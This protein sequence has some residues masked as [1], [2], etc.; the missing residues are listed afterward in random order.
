MKHSIRLTGPNGAHA[1]LSHR[2][3][4]SFSPATARKYHAQWLAA[5]PGGIARIETQDREP[6][7]RPVRSY[8]GTVT[9]EQG[10]LLNGGKPTVRSCRFRMERD[11]ENWVS[12]M[13]AQPFASVGRVIPSM[14]SPELNALTH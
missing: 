11:C 1:Y 12:A 6:V 4:V 14:K 13:M 2:G 9:A 10:H 7:K 8:F 5:N 3:K